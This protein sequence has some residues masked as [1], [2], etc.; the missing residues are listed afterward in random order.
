MEISLENLYVDLEAYRVKAFFSAVLPQS[1]VETTVE[2][3]ISLI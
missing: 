2:G 3:W 1:K